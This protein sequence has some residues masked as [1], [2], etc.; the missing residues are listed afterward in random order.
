M[1]GLKQQER[2]HCFGN[3]KIYYLYEISAKN[4]GKTGHTQPGGVQERNTI[5]YPRKK[6]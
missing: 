3:F 2:Q 5:E 4:Y 6:I 1:P